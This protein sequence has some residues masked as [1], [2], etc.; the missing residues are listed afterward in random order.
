MDLPTAILIGF[1]IG[2]TVFRE[3]M[4]AQQVKELEEKLMAR[5]LTEYKIT[6]QRPDDLGG[7]NEIA[8]KDRTVELSSV[9]NPFI[10]NP[11]TKLNFSN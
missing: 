9:P 7:R 6:G 8:E 10:D 5:S 2:F 4:H 11:N 3:L 1:L